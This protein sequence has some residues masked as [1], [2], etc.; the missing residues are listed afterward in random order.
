MFTKPAP[1]GKL[2]SGLPMVYDYD[3]SIF[4]REHNGGL[5][6]GGFEKEAKPIFHN[7]VPKN[8]ECQSLQPDLDHFCKF[9]FYTNISEK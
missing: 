8:F 3:G 5:L 4:I 2:K 6:F 7:F 1:D 9:N